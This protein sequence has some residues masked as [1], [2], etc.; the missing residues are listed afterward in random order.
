MTWNLLNYPDYNNVSADTAIR[1][2]YFRTVVQYVNPDILVTQ[3]NSM[4]TGISLF[5]NGVMNAGGSS[6]YSAGAF[7]NGYDTDNGVFYRTSDFSF[8][9]NTRIYTDLRDINEFKLVHLVTGDTIRIYSCHLKA[10]YGPPNDAQRALEVDSLRKATNALPAGTDFIVC[11][12]FN[13]Y[14]SF[15]PAY[16]KLLADNVTDDGNFIDPYSMSG[17]WN[18]P[19]YSPFHTQSTRLTSFGGGASGGLND[20]FDMILYSTAVSQSGRITYV[21]N[22]MTPIGNDGNH[23]NLSIN[24]MPNVAVPQNVANALY[25]ASDHLPLTANFEFSSVTVSPE[26][27]QDN[28]SVNVFPDPLTENSVIEF[29]CSGPSKVKIKVYNMPGSM[30]R[31]FAYAQLKKG[32]SRIALNDIYKMQPG[33]YLLKIFFNDRVIA[34]RIVIASHF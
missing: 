13:I 11:G 3:E 33:I 15:E 10:S 1:N 32:R 2:P 23:Y 31:E 21:P 12:D 16:A 24:T 26:F 5:L 19:L 27:L 28:A 8:I 18:Q 22:S 30:V 7:I 9:S 25:F 17:T 14:N 6:I 4:T 34:K 20:R 29:N